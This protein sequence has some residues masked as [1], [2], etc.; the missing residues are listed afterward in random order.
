MRAQL[1][2]SILLLTPAFLAMNGNFSWEALS[3]RA[4][5]RVGDKSSVRVKLN[6]LGF[7]TE[8]AYE[9]FRYREIICCSAL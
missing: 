1:F 6:E 5:R 7:T 3:I 2:T 8:E 4:I 9:N